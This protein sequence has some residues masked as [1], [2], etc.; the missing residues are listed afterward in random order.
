MK[1]VQEKDIN[2]GNMIVRR[3]GCE[4]N[5]KP[6]LPG[7]LIGHQQDNRAS[8][9]IISVSGDPRQSEEPVDA[10]VLWTRLPFDGNYPPKPVDPTMMTT[11]QKMYQMQLISRESMLRQAG[12]DPNERPEDV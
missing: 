12:L 1:L 8:G 4:G 2:R 9:I 10:L 11:L 5:N 6:F 7:D 3:H